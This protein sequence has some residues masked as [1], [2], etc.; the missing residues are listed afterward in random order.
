MPR[1]VQLVHG[2]PPNEVAGT[3]VYTQRVKVGLEARGWEVL[4]I[5]STR[6][7]AL[8]H[9][10]V[11]PD[12]G[13]V[14]VV[15]NLPWRPLSQNEKDPLI[16]GRVRKAVND[17]RPDLVHVQH[18]LFLSAHLHLKAPAIATLH[19]AWGWCPRTNLLRD[20]E[21]PCPG[22][23]E[24]DCPSCY[25]PLV[26][27]SASDARMLRAAGALSRVVGTDTLHAAWKRVPARIKK[28][29]PTATAQVGELSGRQAAVA[30]A[31]RRMDRLLAPSRYLASLATENGLGEVAHL[32]HGVAA[33]APRRG[34]GP[35]VFLGSLV[36][37]KG[38]H[39]VAEAIPDAQIYGPATDA[40]YAAALPN[41]QGAIPNRDVPALLAGAE[42]LVLGSTW[43]EN[44]PLVVL[45]ARAS[46]CPVVAPRI[47][48]LPEIVE[49][50]VDG[51]LYEPG[52]VV[53]L[54]DAME[55]LRRAPPRPNSPPSFEEHL[56]G[57]IEH[58]A[59]VMS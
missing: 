16:E 27:G 13:V 10:S 29:R 30:A 53:A 12:E 35:P 43:P 44:A 33:G 47:G 7:P 8:D 36:P 9:G 48:G 52:D 38:A 15:N 49:D 19:D 21:R 32:P 3:E 56:D 23:S 11:H 42:A 22:P 50:G 4:V 5:A 57:L 46:G 2:Y 40:S 1:L 26:V 28:L 37:H 24:T 41:L 17:F 34:G 31:F 45:E 20:G 55:R 58:Y 51:V 59:A 39:L 25:A 6:A 14:R 18:L 54:R